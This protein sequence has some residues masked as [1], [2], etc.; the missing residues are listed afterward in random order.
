MN[1]ILRFQP[2][3]HQSFLAYFFKRLVLSLSLSYFPTFP[4]LSLGISLQMA[5]MKA[6]TA[7][8]AR[9]ALP[10][11][12][13]HRSCIHKIVKWLQIREERTLAK[14]GFAARLIYT[15]I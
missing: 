4:S 9:F 15:G 10:C 13:R 2:G 3:S 14:K 5:L 7:V 8:A 1:F 11:N 12:Q 6:N